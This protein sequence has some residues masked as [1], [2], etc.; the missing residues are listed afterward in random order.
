LAKCT[1]E[2]FRAA[3]S[4]SNII[5]TKRQ[6]LDIKPLCP[7][8]KVRSAITAS[9]HLKMHIEKDVLCRLLSYRQPPRR[10]APYHK[11]SLVEEALLYKH[12]IQLEVN[13]TNSMDGVIAIFSYYVIYYSK[14]YYII[15]CVSFVVAVLS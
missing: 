15:E 2:L 9:K 1:S 12:Y 13:T 7:W 8:R 4:R 10:T 5:Q 14:Q 11:R 6:Y 3:Y